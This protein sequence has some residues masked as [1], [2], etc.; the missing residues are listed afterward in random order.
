MK[1]LRYLALLPILALLSSCSTLVVTPEYSKEITLDEALKAWNAVLKAYVDKHGQVDFSGL[2]KNRAN[3]DL[4]VS[5]VTKV[6]P[7]SRPEMF[8]NFDAKLAHYLNSYNAL[9]MFSIIDS[10]I[11]ESLSG[12]KKVKFFYF[13]KFTIDGE[14]MSLYKYENE[15]I[16]KQGEEKVHFALN[17]MSRGC[18]RLPQ[19]AFAAKDLQGELTKQA[20]FFFSEDRNVKVDS[21]EKVVFLSEIL[22]FFPEDFLKKA[23]SVIAY[24]NLYRMQ[25]LPEDF[26]TDFIPYDWTV[27]AQPGV[28]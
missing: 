4:Y 23:P 22:N 12:F 6:G 16:R 5:F 15:I 11:P 2:S 24:A 25:K 1:Q 20:K 9:S 10:G 14:T 28:Q 26:K 17:C 21:T 8:P 3:L 18:P 7:V 27:N 13:K 19:V